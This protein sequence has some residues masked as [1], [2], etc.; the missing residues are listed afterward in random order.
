MWDDVIIGKKHGICGAKKVFGIENENISENQME[1]WI[2]NCIMDLGIT[3]DKATREG[4]RLTAMIQ[5]KRSKAYIQRFLDK[6]ILK[7]IPVSKLYQ[8][9]SHF[10]QECIQK[11]KDQK[12]NEILSALGV[13]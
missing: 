13:V 9:I 6:L 4:Q 10:K 12:Q 11:G 2:P 5:H 3:I 7:H 8:K 1:Y